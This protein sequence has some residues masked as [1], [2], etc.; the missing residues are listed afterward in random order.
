MKKTVTIKCSSAFV[1]GG[2]V[3]TKGQEV[4]GVPERDALALVRRGK[5]V[6]VS[7]DAAG[8]DDHD[9]LQAMKVDDLK[10][11]ARSYEIEGAEGMKKAELV[12]AIE[13]AVGEGDE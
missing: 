3:I 6:I 9:D 1:A 11:L 5:A 13:A 10:T 7:D 4:A 8:A 2:K 12:E